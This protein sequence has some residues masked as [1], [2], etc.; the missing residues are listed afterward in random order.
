[1]SDAIRLASPLSRS[2]RIFKAR[3]FLWP[4]AGASEVAKSCGKWTTKTSRFTAG[5]FS[6]SRNRPG[7]PA[8]P[9][10]E[11]NSAAASSAGT[12]TG[13]TSGR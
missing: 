11:A 12:G 5:V 2:W 4:A 13:R 10:T 1:M 6:G 8:A 9:S 7:A 3:T